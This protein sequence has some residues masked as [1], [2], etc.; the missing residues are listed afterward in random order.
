MTVHNWEVRILEVISMVFVALLLEN[1]GTKFRRPFS[2]LRIFA[3][4]RTSGR[5]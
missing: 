5:I 1:V 2:P 3:I 4:S